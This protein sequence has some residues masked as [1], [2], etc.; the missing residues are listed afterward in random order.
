MNP[1]LRFITL[2]AIGAVLA[3]LNGYLVSVVF[4]REVVIWFFAT[5]F[6]AFAGGLKGLLVMLA[7]PGVLGASWA[8]PLTCVVFPLTGLF[9][10]GSAA[11]PFLF[12]AIGAVAGTL[13]AYAWIATGLKPIQTGAWYYFVAG[14]VG[15]LSTGAIFGFA[16]WRIDAITARR[17]AAPRES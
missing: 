15:G 10:R 1:A 14:A 6:A 3:P 11:T 8:W 16:L 5:L 12:A 9:I 7:L 13:T 17:A 2:V 4:G